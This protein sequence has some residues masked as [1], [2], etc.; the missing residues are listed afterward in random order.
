MNGQTAIEYQLCHLGLLPAAQ[1]YPLAM[2]KVPS[3]SACAR[4]SL[5]S[6]ASSGVSVPRIRRTQPAK[7]DA[8]VIRLA[9]P[10]Q[11]GNGAKAR[12]AQRDRAIALSELREHGLPLR[13]CQIERHQHQW[14]D[15]ATNVVG[16]LRPS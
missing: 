3:A 2:K 8:D 1:W 5:N 15:R 11:K 13:R 9:P 12:T 16:N 14:R 7:D 4:A 6:A 10:I